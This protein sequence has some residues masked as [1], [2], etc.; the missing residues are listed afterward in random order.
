MQIRLVRLD[1][2]VKEDVLL[3]KIDTEGYEVRYSS[4]PS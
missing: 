4:K 1:E 2:I 3:L